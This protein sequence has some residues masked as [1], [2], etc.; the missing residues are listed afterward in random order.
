MLTLKLHKGQRDVYNDPNKVRVV[1][2]GRRWGKSKLTVYELLLR[3]LS[4]SGKVDP[5][6]TETVL[7]VLP[8]FQAA[9]RILWQ[10][11]YNLCTETE[12]STIVE[13]I[14]KVDCK[15]TFKG[16]KPPIVIAGANDGGDRLRGMRL[17]FVCLDEYQDMKHGTLDE[18]IMPATADTTGSRLLITGT[19]KG[20]LNCLATIAER[21]KS[22]PDTYSFYNLPTYTNP[23]IDRREVEL[24][25]LTLP[26]RTF[27]QEYEA[28]FEDFEGKIFSELGDDNQCDRLPDS[29]DLT[30][31]GL[32]WGDTNPAAV[33]WGLNKGNWY[34]CEAWQPDGALP[35]PEPVRDTHIK[36]LGSKWNVRAVYCDPS[37]PSSII[38]IRVLGKEHNIPGLLKAV[39]GN[40]RI[41]EG[42]DHVH[43]LIYQ[44]KLM[45]PKAPIGKS[46]ECVN[47]ETAYLKFEAYHRKTNKEGIVTAEVAPNQDDHVIDASR[48]ALVTSK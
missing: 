42:I 28:S 45:F 5:V 16:G 33:V 36:R 47:G 29:F 44:K 12:L 31:M 19:P 15:I 27:R 24:A 26:P 34:W 40:N 48:Y 17:Y 13:H 23:T 6:S 41:N 39:A 30:I 38:G 11:L 4:F 10:P 18:V 37:R 2:C 43:S 14:S 7:G 32:D 8:T 22:F 20:K 25:R 1:V 35:V 21:A 9:K 46:K 3:S